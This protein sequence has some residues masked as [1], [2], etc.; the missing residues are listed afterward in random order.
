M[1]R[2]FFL[3]EAISKCALVETTFLLLVTVSTVNLLTT[4]LNDAPI[5]PDEDSEDAISLLKDS[6]QCVSFGLFMIWYLV[7]NE[8]VL[9]SSVF[10][11]LERELF[12]VSLFIN[13]NFNL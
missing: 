9:L 2:S 8:H 6:P 13:Y 4:V 5:L 3:C 7:I 11:K 10:F 12:A 1:G